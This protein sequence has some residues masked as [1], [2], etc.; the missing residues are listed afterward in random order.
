MTENAISLTPYYKGWDVY[1]QYLVTAISPL[2]PEQLTLRSAPHM[3]SVGVLAT[4]I[5]GTRASWFHNWMGEGDSEI[6]RISEWDENVEPTRP[7]AELV[8]GLETTW[9]MIQQALSRWTTAD[10]EQEFKNPYVADR[11]A[12]TR[13]WIIW[14]LIEHDLHHGGELSLTLGM[15]GVPGLDL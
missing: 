5:A 13:Q 11:P 4:H 8:A 2:T 10:L 12:R 1:Q 3:W 6:A 7:A 15:H 9:H 14:H